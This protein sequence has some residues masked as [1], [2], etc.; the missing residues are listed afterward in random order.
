MENNETNI[1]IIEMI[2]N[3]LNSLSPIRRYIVY[4]L[5]TL[6]MGTLI[7]LVINKDEAFKLVQTATYPDGC[8]ETYINGVLQGENCTYG[9]SLIE[10]NKNKFTTDNIDTTGWLILNANNTGTPNPTG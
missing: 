8:N 1:S 3:K 4:F 10:G 6:L 7:F 2:K 9:R 5:V